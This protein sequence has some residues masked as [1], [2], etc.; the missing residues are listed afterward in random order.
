PPYFR[1]G[2]MPTLLLL[3]PRFSN[4]NAK[5]GALRGG[6]CW[7]NISRTYQEALSGLTPSPSPNLGRG[8]QITAE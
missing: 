6:C 7:R 8:E 4:A 5:G 2:R 1:A 3:I